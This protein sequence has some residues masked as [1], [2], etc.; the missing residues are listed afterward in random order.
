MASCE[1]QAGLQ[2]FFMSFGWV[3]TVKVP[4][5]VLG[6]PPGNVDGTHMNSTGQRRN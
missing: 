6:R 5:S 2:T 3:Q 1:L 4:L